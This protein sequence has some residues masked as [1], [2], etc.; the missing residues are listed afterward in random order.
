MQGLHHMENNN[1]TEKLKGCWNKDKSPTT[2]LFYKEKQMVLL[3][4]IA[5]KGDISYI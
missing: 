1:N 5:V 2:L 3:R 4:D